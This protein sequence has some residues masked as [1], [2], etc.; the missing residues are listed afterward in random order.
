MGRGVVDTLGSNLQPLVFHVQ[1]YCLQLQ[2]L[3]IWMWCHFKGAL[4]T[5]ASLYDRVL[6]AQSHAFQ[7]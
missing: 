1:N 7:P 5:L 6:Q 2:I 3:S 4:H